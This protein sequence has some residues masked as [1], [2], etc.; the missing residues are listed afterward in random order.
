MIDGKLAEIRFYSNHF[1]C[2]Q[3][4][5][6]DQP[7]QLWQVEMVGLSIAVHRSSLI[8]VVHM[9]WIYHDSSY[10]QFIYD[11]SSYAVA[12]HW[13]PVTITA[14][15][16]HSSQPERKLHLCQ[17]IGRNSKRPNELEMSP[18]FGGRAFH[19][20]PVIFLSAFSTAI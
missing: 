3:L 4:K 6:P 19:R 12:F 13:H 17:H 16:A 9:Q 5:W 8:L 14:N 15:S 20:F 1:S 7:D 11:G 18:I 2:H 10:M